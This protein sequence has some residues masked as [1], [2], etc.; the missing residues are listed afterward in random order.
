MSRKLAALAVAKH[1]RLRAA[2][3]DAQIQTTAIGVQPFALQLLHLERGE[4]VE[5]PR[6]RAP[7]CQPIFERPTLADARGQVQT[8]AARLTAS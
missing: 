4:S 6:H 3:R 1:P 8:A 7:Q 2:V 5:C